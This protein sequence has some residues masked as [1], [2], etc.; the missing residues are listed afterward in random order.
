MKDLLH[1]IERMVWLQDEPISDPVCVF[2][3][4]FKASSK[5]KVKVCQVGEG[6]DELFIGYPFWR[7]LFFLQKLGDVKLETFEKTCQNL[8]KSNRN[9]HGRWN[10]KRNE[11]TT[12]LWSG[13]EAFTDAQ[14]S[15]YFQKVFRQVQRYQFKGSNCTILPKIQRKVWRKTKIKLMSYVD[16]NLRLPDL[17]L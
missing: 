4:C 1:F 12:Y 9:T 8:F 15:T 5:R 6:A 7:V 14:K 13:A 17:F 16:L 3:L 11:P 10:T 2:V